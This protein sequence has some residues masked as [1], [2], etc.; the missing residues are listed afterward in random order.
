MRLPDANFAAV[1]GVVREFDEAKGYGT[2]EADG[3]ARYFFHC[4]QIT[5]GSRTIPVRALVRFELRPW[6]R[7]QREA[8]EIGP[9]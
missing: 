6:H 2:I 3:G 1:F 5:D 8:V 4:T 9:R 7:G